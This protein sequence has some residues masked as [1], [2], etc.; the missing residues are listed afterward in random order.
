M[1]F[2][3]FLFAQP[4]L[5]ESI[6]SSSTCIFRN[7]F[8]LTIP[9]PAAV[10]PSSPVNFRPPLRK[11]NT[12]LTQKLKVASVAQ[13]K[14]PGLEVFED[15]FQVLSVQKKSVQGEEAWLIVLMKVTWENYTI[16]TAVL[17]VNS[18]VFR[19]R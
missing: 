10:P 7:L 2:R 19:N 16:I 12:L 5:K 6:C 9:H 14:R 18:N 4:L 1:S 3:K 11:G 8:Q 15:A 13:Q 17:Q